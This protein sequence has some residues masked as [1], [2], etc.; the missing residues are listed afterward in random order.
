VSLPKHAQ[1]RKPKDFG[2]VEFQ[3]PKSIS[4]AIAFFKTFNGVLLKDETDPANLASIKAHTSNDQI[5]P[6]PDKPALKRPMNDCEDDFLAKKSKLEGN[7]KT[8][9]KNKSSFI[10]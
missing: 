10:Y 5:K 7:F 3:K 6:Q 4:K 9:G 1:T 8:H 2:F